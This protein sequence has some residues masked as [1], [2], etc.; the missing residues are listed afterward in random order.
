M[1]LRL[2]TLPSRSPP[3]TVSKR[4]VLPSDKISVALGSRQ[5]RCMSQRGWL[6]L[7]SS[8]LISLAATVE[9]LLRCSSLQERHICH[10]PW[11]WGTSFALLCSWSLASVSA[12][13]TPHSPAQLIV[14]FLSPSLPSF[15]CSFGESSWLSAALSE[16]HSHGTGPLCCPPFPGHPCQAYD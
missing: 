15:V 7:G 8:N 16:P 9:V 3:S 14:F 10:R 5:H 4:L 2:F 6:P 12:Q 11:V 1:G 13:S